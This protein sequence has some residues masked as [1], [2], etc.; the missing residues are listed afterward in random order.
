MGRA[1]WTRAARRPDARPCAAGRLSGRLGASEV[2]PRS[3]VKE[4]G[5]HTDGGFH[6]LLATSRIPAELEKLQHRVVVSLIATVRRTGVSSLG[7]GCWRGARRSTARALRARGV[8]RG[9]PMSERQSGISLVERTRERRRERERG[10]CSVPPCATGRQFGRCWH[11]R[12]SP[13]R[14][15][16]VGLCVR[17]AARVRVASHRPKHYRIAKQTCDRCGTRNADTRIGARRM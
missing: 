17:P 16:A 8:G 7:S 4:A 14:G 1:A 11:E 2:T 5:A 13:R 15:F 3:P 10:G 12:D 9:L 6:Q